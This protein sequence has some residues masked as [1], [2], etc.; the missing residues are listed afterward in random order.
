M[1]PRNCVY[2][3]FTALETPLTRICYM[4]QFQICTY[5]NLQKMEGCPRSL[6]LKLELK[7]SHVTSFAPALKRVSIK[8]DLS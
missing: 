5:E 7:E 4:L 1:V 6:M 3:K 2:T 8:Q